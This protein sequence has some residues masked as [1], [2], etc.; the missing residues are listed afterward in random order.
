MSEADGDF[1]VSVIIG[2]ALWLHAG[3]CWSVCRTL[4]D[5]RVEMAEQDVN[6]PAGRWFSPLKFRPPPV[7]V[8]VPRRM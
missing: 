8:L 6:R 2:D 3:L 5:A 1:H 4:P 7:L